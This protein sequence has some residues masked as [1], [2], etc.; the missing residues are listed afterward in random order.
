MLDLLE[1]QFSM[2]DNLLL[3][4]QLKFHLEEDDSQNKLVAAVRQHITSLSTVNQLGTAWLNQGKI[5][6][7]S[8]PYLTQN[9]GFYF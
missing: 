3:V 7:I 6:L 5:K 9:T 4:K 1:L 8:L 2:E